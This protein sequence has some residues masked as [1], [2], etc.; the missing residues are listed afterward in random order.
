M[1]TKRT[2]EDH[3]KMPNCYDQN[4]FGITKRERERE[5]ERNDDDETEQI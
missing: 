4:R 1:P 5:R 2:E 3:K